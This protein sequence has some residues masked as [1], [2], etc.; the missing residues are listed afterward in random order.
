MTTDLAER[1]QHEIRQ[2]PTPLV[3]EVLDFI[4]YLAHRHS[5]RTDFN[6]EELIAIQEDAMRHVWDNPDDE[7]WNNVPTW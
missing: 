6:G 7:V 3:Q 4:G 2:L 5:L 1:V